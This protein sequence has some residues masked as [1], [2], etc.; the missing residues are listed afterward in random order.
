MRIQM[1]A[2]RVTEINAFYS[3][4]LNI[5]LVYIHVV[6]LGFTTEMIWIFRVN[7]TLHCLLTE[8]I[9][10]GLYFI[11]KG[12]SEMERQVHD[13]KFLP[14]SSS[15]SYHLNFRFVGRSPSGFFC[16]TLFTS[17]YNCFFQCHQHVCVD[18]VVRFGRSWSEVTLPQWCEWWYTS[19]GCQEGP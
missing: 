17:L 11:A 9:N 15:S 7:I 1:E 4:F 2:K 5:F 3:Y 10:S 18:F 16:M 19:V 12:I 8:T 14:S 13:L 6:F